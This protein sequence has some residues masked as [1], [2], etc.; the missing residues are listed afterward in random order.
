MFRQFFPRK[1]KGRASDSQNVGHSGSARPLDPA[2]AQ[3]AQQNLAKYLPQPAVDDGVHRMALRSGKQKLPD[4]PDELAYSGDQ[5]DHAKL[6]QEALQAGDLRRS[7]YHLALALADDPEREEWL[8]L[9]DQW[10]AAA[11][12]RALE[13]VPLYDREYFT[14]LEASRHLMQ[15][16]NTPGHRMEVI[17]IVGK[18]YHAKVAVHAAI[19]VAQGRAREGVA[20]LLQLVGVKPEIA[21]ITWLTR[22]QNTLDLVA[23]LEPAKVAAIAVR[24]MQK[25]PGSY[26]FSVEAHEELSRHLPLLRAC[27]LALVKQP[28]DERFLTVGFA[29]AAVLRKTGAFEEAAR[30]ARTLPAAYQTRVSLAMAEEALGNLDASIAA[31]R[32]AL[33]F[34]P[35]DVAVR[36]D[37]GTIYLSQGKLAEALALYEESVRLDPK[38][39][40]EQAQAHIA[41]LRYVLT[42]EPGQLQ[43]LQKLAKRQD[44]ANK[45]LYLLQVPYVGKLPEPGEA[46]LN[47]IRGMQA[48]QA[49]GEIKTLQGG[50]FNVGLSS[51]EAPSARL[52]AQRW[53]DAI[54]ASYALNVSDV[55]T[56]DPRVPLRPVEYQIWRYQEFDPEPA[57]SAPDPAIAEQVSKIAQTPYALL[58]WYAQAHAIGQQLGEVAL[59]DLLGV[60]VH[61]PTT[62]AGWDEWDWITAVQ[63]ASALTIACLGDESVWEGS[64]RKAAL[65]SLVYGPTD[66]SGAA[67]LIAL[68]VLA[69]QNKRITIEFDALC[70]DLWSLG[71]GTAEWPHEQAMVFGLI[72]VNHYSSESRKYIQD[73]FAQMKQENQ[74]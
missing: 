46:L 36:N 22:W 48:K 67:A 31:Y 14:T 15:T 59:M 54:G 28:T 4:D 63:I 57:V 56:P 20:L 13:F 43:T 7:I 52:A 6:A 41:Y 34:E 30:V 19:L 38:D 3:E 9:L 45:L 49:A 18:H 47:L 51:L 25:Y 21:Y 16:G 37:L 50:K 60:M 8:T 2:E 10:I 32:E 73:Y 71:R 29:Y 35:N 66:W 65:T 68:A 12:S 64:R 69:N 53:A 24:T 72:F 42:S 33:S 70:R 61:P 11:G 39:P 44:T 55:L 58:R 23:A 26:V 1:G 40:Y 74:E 27:Y 5:G 62:P 17:P